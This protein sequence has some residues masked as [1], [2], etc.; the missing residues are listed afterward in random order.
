[1]EAADRIPRATSI[2]ARTS[3]RA[4][5]GRG[6]LT[7]E[8]VERLPLGRRDDRAEENCSGRRDPFV[9]RFA[10]PLVLPT[11]IAPAAGDGGCGHERCG[12]APGC[13][14]LLFAAAPHTSAATREGHD[15]GDGTATLGGSSGRV[16]LVRALQT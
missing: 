2:P 12:L 3:L 14:P 1:M 9:S 13:I 15:R 11:P 6:S 16:L 7:P 4:G 10:L 8:G 5:R